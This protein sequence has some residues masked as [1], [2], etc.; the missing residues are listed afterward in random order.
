M[1]LGLVYP[2]RSWQAHCLLTELFLL[3]SLL[4]FRVMI[5]VARVVRGKRG[6]EGGSLGVVTA[7]S[8]GYRHHHHKISF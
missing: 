2:A 4:V 3:I 7:A 8:A 5:V 1:F 6:C